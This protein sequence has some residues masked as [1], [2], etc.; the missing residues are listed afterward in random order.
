MRARNG[1]LVFLDRQVGIV[2]F[3]ELLRRHADEP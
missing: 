2:S 3:L 1:R